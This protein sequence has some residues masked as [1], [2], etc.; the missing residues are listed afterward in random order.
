M[1][2]QQDILKLYNLKVMYIWLH[3][4]DEGID[5]E[6]ILDPHCIYIEIG[7]K[8]LKIC[9]LDGKI[10]LTIRSKI[11][12]MSDMDIIYKID[13]RNYILDYPET[14]YYVEKIGG[15]NMEINANKII[16][17]AVELDVFTENY[18]K[19][20]IF[21][22]SGLYGLR[23]GGI[24][25]KNNWIKNWYFPIYGKKISENWFY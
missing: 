21:I 17:D 7:N 12:Y 3:P 6:L 1:N 19:Q 25:K 20:N 10:E 14:D 2:Y 4:F 22:H 5:N 15:I 18:G 8:F 23:I 11:D 13:L 16:C 24:D 9:D